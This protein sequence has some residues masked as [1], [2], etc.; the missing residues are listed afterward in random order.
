[1]HNVHLFSKHNSGSG[2]LAPQ[3]ARASRDEGR[4][5]QEYDNYKKKKKNEK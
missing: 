1:M 3:M 4:L 2:L 5:T